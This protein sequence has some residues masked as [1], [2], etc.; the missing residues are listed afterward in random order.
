MKKRRS[1]VAFALLF[2]FVASFSGARMAYAE[3]GEDNAGD[4]R[5]GVNGATL[6]LDVLNPLYEEP[7]IPRPR[8][9]LEDGP[10]P[11]Q[12]DCAKRGGMLDCIANAWCTWQNDSV[13]VVKFPPA[14]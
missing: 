3:D 12:D 10:R 8:V 6:P 13:C 4:A 5:A 14:P 9:L 11:L 1:F 2:A 7:S